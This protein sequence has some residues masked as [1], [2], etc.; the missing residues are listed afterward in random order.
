VQEAFDKL[1]G[2]TEVV[3]GPAADGGYYLLAARREALRPELFRDIDWSTPTVLE[4][5]RT[6]CAELGLAADLLPRAAD[7][8][9]PADLDRLASRLERRPE[10]DCPR[11][12]QLLAR[13]GRVSPPA[14]EGEGNEN[15]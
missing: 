11:T 3:L 2:G 10:I 13:W 4:T 15:P 14:I 5:T 9:T 7:V 8:D 1:A 12:R 6:R